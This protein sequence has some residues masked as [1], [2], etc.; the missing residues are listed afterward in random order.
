MQTYAVKKVIKSI[1]KKINGEINIERLYFIFFNRIILKNV[2][3]VSNQSNELIDSLKTHRGYNDTLLSCKKISIVFSPKDLLKMNIKLTSATLADGMFN[4]QN[5]ADT[6]DGPNE[7]NIKRIFGT[8]PNKQKDTTK[9]LPL[10]LIANNLKIENFRFY[11]KNHLRYRFRH[12]ETINFADLNLSDINVD[13]RDINIKNDTLFAQI[14]NIAAKDISGFK[15]KT[16]Q[17]DLRVSSTESRI[18]NIFLEDSFSRITGKFYSMKYNSVK[19]FSEFVDNVKLNIDLN[20][21]YLD[22]KTIGRFAPTLLESSLSFYV[23][24][25]ASGTVRNLK[26]SLLTITSE[27][28]ET[29]LEVSAKLRGLPDVE[30]TM[31]T[32]K[33]NSCSTTGNDI[34]AIVSSINN[35][36]PLPFFKQ[37]PKGVRYNFTGNFTGLL[38]DFVANGKIRSSVGNINLD[39]LL[40][41]A[42][43]KKEG[44]LLKGKI[45]TSNL[46]LGKIFSNKLLGKLTMNSSITAQ[47]REAA[48]GGPEVTIDSIKIKELGLNNYNYSNI[49]ALGKY[50]RDNFDGRIICHDPNL[51]F[52]FQGL[53]ALNQKQQSR[54]NF[55]LDIPYANL[56]EMN[57]DKRDSISEVRLTASANFTKFESGDILGNI[58]I[59]NANYTNSTGDYP[60]GNIKLIAN[61]TDT[62]HTTS[63]NSSF[64]NAEFKGTSAFATFINK[65]LAITLYDQYDNFF[66]NKKPKEEILYSKDNFKFNLRT[67]D[68]RG[69]CEFL[70]PGLYI[71]NGTTISSKISPDNDIKFELLSGRVAYKSNYLKDLSLR[72]KE[73]TSAIKVNLL[74]QTANIGGV[75]LDSLYIRMR[76]RDNKIVASLGF[77]EKDS[78]VDNKA[79]LNA[80]VSFFNDSIKVNKK[81]R[82]RKIINIGLF[83]SQVTL[84][85]ENWKITPSQI[86]IQDSITRFKNISLFNGNQNINIDGA[87]SKAHRDSVG[88]TLN[89]FDLSV[90][91]LLTSKDMRFKGLMSGT[92][93][94]SNYKS[95]NQLFLDLAGDSVYVSNRPV[96]DLRVLSKWDQ[97]NKRFNLLLST[98]LNNVPNFTASGYL[99]PVNNNIDINADLRN[100]KV[101]YFEPF[102]SSIISGMTGTISGDLSLTGTLKKPALHSSNASV[103]NF[104]F[105]V[106]FT[107]V[108]YILNGA[109]DVSPNGVFSKNLKIQDML[110]HSGSVSGGLKYDHF[111]NLYLDTKVNFND[112]EFLK[113]AESDNDAFYGTAFATGNLSIKGPFNKILLEANI[114][115]DPKTSIHIPLSNSAT[116]Q[117]TNILTFT[118]P[119]SDTLLIDTYEQTMAANKVKQA[120]ELDIKLNTNI[121]PNAEIMI[122]INKAVGDVIKANGNGAISMN[123]NP[124]K[125]IFDMYGEYIISQ[126]SYKFVFMG[127]APKD[128]TIQPGGIINFNGGISNTTLNLTAVYRTKASINTLIADTSSIGTRRT[129][130]CGLTMSGNLMNPQLAFS[131]NIPDLDPTI[132]VMVENALNTPGKVQKQFM[133]ILVSGGFIPDEQSG[134]ANNS[135]ILYSNASEILSNQLNN[136]LQQ[137]NIPIDLGLNYQPGTKGTNIFDVAVSTQLFNNRVLINGNLGNDPYSN[138]NNRDVVGNIDVEVKLDKSGKLRLTLFSHASDKFSNYLDDKQRTGLGIGYQQEFNSFKDIFKR[139]KKLTKEERLKAKEAKKE[140]RIKLKEE[141]LK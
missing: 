17:G 95:E 42:T 60:L 23:T 76:G 49:F 118:Q 66:I 78:T 56:S 40:N 80:M 109:L 35:T 105:T 104:G 79:Q 22:F 26:T 57:L 110:G 122:E 8:N 36:P 100:L 129:V 126:G 74:S 16:L 111:K 130:D 7:S 41:T 50:T 97:I 19:D 116:A 46:N 119:K 39:A 28:G 2:S 43:S 131:I 52:I 14:N 71:Q 54:Y 64:V 59:K 92:A 68:T 132:Q 87:L 138:I 58:D 133:A 32:A 90:L 61:E 55:Y 62:T 117:Q 88:L 98:K 81:F 53:L 45:N 107:G 135:T 47:F 51:D 121:N 33:V 38:T 127:F 15:L 24:G 11:L 113:T 82:P 128:F 94:F 4:I 25:Q 115:S 70:L 73:D 27:S 29:I 75:N 112:L 106:D 99:D 136:I 65:F 6:L 114:T 89:R 67:S 102:F 1:E 44:V 21:S 108:Q 30:E 124:S 5:E 72:I 140:K 137:L 139:K 3:V 125:G 103:S 20:D 10:N 91:N 93:I 37:L 85:G 141:R 86:I 31:M 69:I 12:N 9:S 96:G 48:Y 83:N 34:S 18:D 13:I 63:L 120:S 84:K 123:V 134:I 77:D 101:G